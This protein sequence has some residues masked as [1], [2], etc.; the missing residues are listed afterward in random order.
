MY[1][2]YNF[3]KTET[4]KFADLMKKTLLNLGTHKKMNFDKEFPKWKNENVLDSDFMNS[5][6]FSI[7]TKK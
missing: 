4:M 1:S 7:G 3:F 6:N 5:I 2:S